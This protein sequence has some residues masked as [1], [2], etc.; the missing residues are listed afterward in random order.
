M[1]HKSFLR[2]MVIGNTKFKVFFI[3]GSTSIVALQYA[4]SRRYAIFHNFTPPSFPLQ[5]HKSNFSYS[6]PALAPTVLFS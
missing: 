1:L 2:D 3:K 5:P 4:R 6:V